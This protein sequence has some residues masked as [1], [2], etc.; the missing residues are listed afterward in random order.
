[1]T[2][3]QWEKWDL[4]FWQFFYLNVL[5]PNINNQTKW[6]DTKIRVVD[7]G[8]KI[9]RDSTGKKSKKVFIGKVNLVLNFVF[10]INIKK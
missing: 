8:E 7:V 5:I 1:M 2:G 3:E 6:F 4:A 10:F 9:I